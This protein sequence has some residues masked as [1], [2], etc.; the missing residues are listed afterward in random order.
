MSPLINFERN[1]EGHFFSPKHN[2]AHSLNDTRMVNLVTLGTKNPLRPDST[3]EE[4]IEIWRNIN[5]RNDDCVVPTEEVLVA[6]RSSSLLD[7]PFGFECTLNQNG[8]S[9]V[10]WKL[11]DSEESLETNESDRTSRHSP[12]DNVEKL[13]HDHAQIVE[14]RQEVTSPAIRL[15]GEQLLRV[16]NNDY[17]REQERDVNLQDQCPFTH[18]GSGILTLGSARSRDTATGI[19]QQEMTRQNAFHHLHQLYKLYKNNVLT[20]VEYA[21]SRKRVWAKLLALAGPTTAGQRLADKSCVDTATKL[22]IE[23]H[24]DRLHQLY[25]DGVMTEKQCCRARE[26]I[27]NRHAKDDSRE[28]QMLRP[29]T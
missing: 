9:G 4:V 8:S 6:N 19:E 24:L 18:R 20:E 17:G 22:E 27:I 5:P 13:H 10:I 1:D 14:E 3:I 7:E 2:H 12:L 25:Q 28:L 15:Y 23:L 21:R 29:S 11:Y 26:R 16:G